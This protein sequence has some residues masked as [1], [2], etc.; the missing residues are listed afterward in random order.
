MMGRV[1]PT[2][3]LIYPTHNRLPIEYSSTKSARPLRWHLY[4][5][6]LALGAALVFSTA[7]AKSSQTIKAAARTDNSSSLAAAVNATDSTLATLVNVH[8]FSPPT[9][10]SP[11]STLS[12]DPAGNLYGAGTIYRLDPATGLLTTLAS[13]DSGTTDNSCMA[14]FVTDGNGHFYGVARTGGAND[15]G[16]LFVFNA[17]TG[18]LTTLV[19]LDAATGSA[20]G[21][22]LLLAPDGSL[23][24]TAPNGG[25]NQKGTAF[26]YSPATG[27]LTVLENFD[28]TTTGAS[29]GTPRSVSMFPVRL[30][31][32]TPPVIFSRPAPTAV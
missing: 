1:D 5:R 6:S 31:W 3:C 17:A 19:N 27:V 10:Q 9:G 16:T 29:P 20:P 21:S 11:A 7:Q 15:A 13:F 23:Y 2:V 30:S 12:I 24:G 28:D 18:T 25:S 8:V 22:A 26:Q 14:P 4:A 32:R